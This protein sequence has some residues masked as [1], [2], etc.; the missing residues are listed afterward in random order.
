MAATPMLASL[1]TIALGILVIVGCV[2]ARRSPKFIRDQYRGDPLKGRSLTK[3]RP[4]TEDEYLRS[5]RAL[6]GVGIVA[7]VLVAGLGVIGVISVA[8]R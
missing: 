7:G 4:K 6:Y 8:L 5:G 2:A 1:A 3:R